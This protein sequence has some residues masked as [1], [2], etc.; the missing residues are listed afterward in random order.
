MGVVA[1]PLVTAEEFVL[2]HGHDSG[3]ELVNGRIVWLPM[4]GAKHG[5]V[6]NKV[7]RLIGNHVEANDLGRTFGNDTFVRVRSNP[8]TYRGPDVCFVSYAKMPKE[9]EVP[10]GPLEF[11]PD[12]VVE[13]RSPSDSIRQMTDKSN[14][15]L[16]AGVRVVVVLDPQTDVVWV[17]RTTD[18]PQRYHNGDVLTITDVLPGFAV[19]VR[20]FFG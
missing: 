3:V 16:D 20:Q 17:T 10:E 4:P 7:S 8:D 19:P 2:R 11:P 15:F 13:V 14:E 9:A 18:W 6:A 1:E 12:L 5:Y